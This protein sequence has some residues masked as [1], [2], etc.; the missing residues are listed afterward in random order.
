M[1]NLMFSFYFTIREKNHIVQLFEWY[2]FEVISSQK[3]QKFQKFNSTVNLFCLKCFSKHSNLQKYV[4]G[5]VFVDSLVYLFVLV[6]CILCMD[7][8]LFV[9]LMFVGF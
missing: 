3:M 4:E 8:F 1:F 7:A 6:G 9:F 2:P 5:F